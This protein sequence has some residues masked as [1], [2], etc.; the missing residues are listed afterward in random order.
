MLTNNKP[1]VSVLIPAYNHE[2]FVERAVRSVLTQTYNN[3][4]LIVL[5]DGSKDDTYQILQSLQNECSNK[6][7]GFI[8]NTQENTGTATTFNRLLKQTTGK[9]ILFLASDD[10]LLEKCIETQVNFLEQNPQYV[11]SVPDNE[12][13]DPN[14][15]RLERAFPSGN[16][17]PFDPNSTHSKTFAHWLQAYRP[18]VPFQSSDF[19]T[20]QSLLTS[21]YLP[22]GIL[23]RKSAIDKCHPLTKSAPLEDW[24]LNLQMSKQGPFHFES[25]ILFR[26]RIHN[27]NTI[28]SKSKL[29][30][31]SLTTRFYDWKL[32]QQ[33]DN[34]VYKNTINKIFFSSQ[35]KYK[36]GCLGIYIIKYQSYFF[37]KKVLE[38]GKWNFTLYLRSLH[39]LPTWWPPKQ[40]HLI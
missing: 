31:L 13:I 33:S 40:D 32:S 39:T 4:E 5:D 9:Y 12:F 27:T 35:K 1:L 24:F 15:G 34:P 28:A 6:L 36:K 17:Y 10:E 21:N 16:F 37:E 11:L 38:I 23:Y 22:N 26:Y 18:D 7:S 14:G 25:Q 8:L 3:I 29:H 19:G 20:Y 30:A 2:K